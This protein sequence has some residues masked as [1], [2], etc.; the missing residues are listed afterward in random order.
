MVAASGTVDFGRQFRPIRYGSNKL[1]KPENALRDTAAQLIPEQR[2][3][4][5]N[6]QNILTNLVDLSIRRRT[7]QLHSD[8]N[9]AMS[10]A[11]RSQATKG[12][13]SPRVR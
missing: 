2:K 1:Y 13:K 9:H 11:S 7:H 3:K 8:P 12:Q 4:L 10:V 5:R 6:G